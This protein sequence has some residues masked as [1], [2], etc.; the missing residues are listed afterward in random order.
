MNEI[1]SDIRTGPHFAT[2]HVTSGG[3]RIEWRL[4]GPDARYTVHYV[5]LNVA[6]ADAYADELQQAW[7]TLRALHVKAPSGVQFDKTVKPDRFSFCIGRSQAISYVI[8]FVHA[9]NSYQLRLTS[10]DQ[11]REFAS[12]I[13]FA[14]GSAS[15]LRE[16]L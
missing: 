1:R 2:L 6:D 11:V 12:A 14:R 10:D 7:A 4:P 5:S 8:P 13:R 9:T 3:A 15:E 16:L